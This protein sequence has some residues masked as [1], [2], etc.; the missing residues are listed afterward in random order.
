MYYAELDSPVGKAVGTNWRAP[1]RRAYNSIQPQTS[2]PSE[3]RHGAENY[4]GIG[5][6]RQSSQPPSVPASL[7]STNPF[8]HVRTAGETRT[9]VTRPTPEAGSP[10]GQYALVGDFTEKSSH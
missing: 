2:N 7:R 6:P 9:V 3:T 10:L 5:W 1:P 4:M 8:G